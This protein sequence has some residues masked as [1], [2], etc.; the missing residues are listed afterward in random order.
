M[1][2]Q[3]QKYCNVGT[4]FFWT[5]GETSISTVPRKTHP[6]SQSWG[7]AG[8]GGHPPEAGN[9]AAGKAAGK[10]LRKS[11]LC[12]YAPLKRSYGKGPG[13][14]VT[15]HGSFSPRVLLVGP[16]TILVAVVPCPHRVAG[17][18]P[19]RR[20]ANVFLQCNPPAANNASED[21]SNKSIERIQRC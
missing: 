20:A 15:L 5:M 7:V 16:D 2:G 1:A 4:V 10:E 8:L 6:S 18:N 3:S 14:P 11:Y 9:T 13:L 12:C 21:A 17:D 19:G